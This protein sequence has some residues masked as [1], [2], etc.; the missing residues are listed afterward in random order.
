V[1]ELGR[2]VMHG[3]GQ[4]LLRNEGVARTYLGG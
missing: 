3:T 2:L 4:E 1:M